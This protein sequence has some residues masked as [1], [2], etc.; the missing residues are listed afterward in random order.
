MTQWDTP[1]DDDVPP[2]LDLAER[3]VYLIGDRGVMKEQMG[4][5]KIKVV[6][7]R[8]F[9]WPEVFK[10]LVFRGFR[11]YVT[12]HKTDLYIEALL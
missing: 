7:P 8:G 3:L 2:P 5:F 11:V 9:P 6:H 12:L 1:G 4:G 10:I